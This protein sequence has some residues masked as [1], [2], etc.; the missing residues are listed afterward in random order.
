MASVHA[1]GEIPDMGVPR[2]CQFS[3]PYDEMCLSC[4]WRRGKHAA[5]SL[6]CIPEGK[7]PLDMTRFEDYEKGRAFVPSSLWGKHNFSRLPDF[8][9]TKPDCDRITPTIL[10]QSQNKCPGC[11]NPAYFGFN[12][13]ECSI[14]CR[15]QYTRR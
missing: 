13:V 11:G 9:R 14:S 4:G 7:S 6:G 3:D 15:P 5:N 10:S 12:S 1:T 8:M 2:P